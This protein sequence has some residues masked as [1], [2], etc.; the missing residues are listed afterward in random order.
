MSTK[1]F[2]GKRMPMMALEEF[3]EWASGLR[4]LVRKKLNDILIKHTIEDIVNIH[5]KY[6]IGNEIVPEYASYDS[7]KI[8]SYHIMLDLLSKK[9]KHYNLNKFTFSLAAFPIGFHILLVPYSHYNEIIEIVSKYKYVEEYAY[10]NNTDKPENLTTE[11]WENRRNAWESVFEKYGDIPND[12]ALMI[13]V[14]NIYPSKI[15]DFSAP[16]LEERSRLMSSDILISEEMQNIAQKRNIVIDSSNVISLFRDAQD[17]VK[18]SD[19]ISAGAS[20][21]KNIL[22][23]EFT[24]IDLDKKVPKPKDIEQNRKI[25]LAKWIEAGLASERQKQEISK[26]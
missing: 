22:Q 15:E 20:I 7:Y 4:E 12:S 19:K 2:D 5:D 21:I 8:L 13:N 26:I 9:D 23:S 25:F 18:S 6:A 24:N 3:A 16:S 1:I 10:W 11:Q 14:G 17:I